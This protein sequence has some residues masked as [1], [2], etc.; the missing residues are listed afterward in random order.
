[1]TL[2]SALTNGS[3]LLMTL[4]MVDRLK[5]M[6]LPML[7]FMC[8][9][10]R[11]CSAGSHLPC[12]GNSPKTVVKH[13]RINVCALC[14]PRAQMLLLLIMLVMVLS[15]YLCTR[16]MQC[17]KREVAYQRTGKYHQSVFL[18][19]G[20]FAGSASN[21]LQ[22]LDRVDIGQ[23]END[24]AVMSGLLYHDPDALV[25]NYDNELFGV[26]EWPKGLEDGCKLLIP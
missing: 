13:D 2:G 19:A 18:N 17:S 20:L 9:Y 8:M 10:C 21:M 11:S 16:E 25:L 5:V 15:S 3:A 4:I 22:L 6:S 1:M 24:Q 23:T 26:A 7:H 12:S 14:L